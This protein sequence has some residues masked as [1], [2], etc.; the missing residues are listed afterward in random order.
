MP[1]PL[2]AAPLNA[3]VIASEACQ[4]VRGCDSEP[5][6]GKWE[7]EKSVFGGTERGA[8]A[9]SLRGGVLSEKIVKPTIFAR[10]L[11]SE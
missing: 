10:Y 11:P 1:V 2:A 9:K 8:E 7:R 3:R 4:S 6:V 5:L